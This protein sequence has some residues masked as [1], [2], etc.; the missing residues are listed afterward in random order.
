LAQTELRETK[1]A[2]S[3]WRRKGKEKPKLA[4]QQSTLCELSSLFFF[5]LPA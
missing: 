2:V 1:A 5:A 4:K 3:R